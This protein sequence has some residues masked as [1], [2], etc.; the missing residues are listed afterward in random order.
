MSK[1]EDGKPKYE[2]PVVMALGELASAVGQNCS[3]GTNGFASCTDGTDAGAACGVGTRPDSACSDGSAP[4]PNPCS[5][6]LTLK[7]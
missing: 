2:A 5:V 7:P 3:V 1:H 4:D 6:G